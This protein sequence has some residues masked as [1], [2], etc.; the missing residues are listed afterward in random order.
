M[1][2]QPFIDHGIVRV[3]KIHDA[4]VLSEHFFKIGDRLFEHRPPQGVIGRQVGDTVDPFQPQ[5]LLDEVPGE[6]ARTGVRQ[7][8]LNLG[9]QNVRLP[10]P[11][12][13]GQLNQFR[14]GNARP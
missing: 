9:L 6:P 13:L 5:P 7:Q 3:Q 14:I 4:E 1:R 8:P 2:R 10:Q 11:A 12:L